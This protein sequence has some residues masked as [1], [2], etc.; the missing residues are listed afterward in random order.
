MPGLQAGGGRG[1]THS[2]STP[3]S[4]FCPR[5]PRNVKKCEVMWGQQRRKALSPG[6]WLLAP[7]HLLVV[8]AR[9]LVARH[10]ARLVYQVHTAGLALAPA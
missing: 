7:L 5:E 9:V 8:G 10:V 2:P 1:V 4:E 3:A 6:H